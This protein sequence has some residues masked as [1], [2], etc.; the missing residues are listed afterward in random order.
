[1]TRSLLHED[2]GIECVVFTPVLSEGVSHI[3]TFLL[4]ES[5]KHTSTCLCKFYSLFNTFIYIFVIFHIY[6][7]VR[8]HSLSCTDIYIL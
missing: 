3:F 4:T 8:C 2:V 1:M 7:Q 6:Y 5:A